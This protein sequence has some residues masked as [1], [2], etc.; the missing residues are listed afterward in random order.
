[1]YGF[2]LAW[3]NAT[4]D[5]RRFLTSVAGITLAV[6]LM[7]TQVGFLTGLYDSQVELV[8]QLHADIIITNALKH[9]MTHNEPF[10]R[11]R[12]QQAQALPEVQTAYPLYIE[13]ALSWWRNPSTGKQRPIR[14]LAF[15]PADPIFLN[16]DIRVHAAALNL[17]NTVLIDTQSK[18]YFGERAAGVVSELSGKRA[19][20][21]GTFRL[22]TDFANE[23]NIMMSARNFLKYFSSPASREARLGKVELGI[24]HLAPGTVAASAVAALR[25]VLPR[26]VT[27]YTKQAYLEHERQ[28]WRKHTPIGAVFGLGAAMGFVIGVII[29][30]Q[31]LYT[32]VVDHLPQFA[33]MKAIG[34]HNQAVIGMVIM[35]ALLLALTGFMLGFICSYAFYELL[36]RWTGLLMRLTLLRMVFVLWSSSWY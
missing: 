29:C 1:M 32:D 25:R 8:N 18:P 15:N 27:I 23:G 4:H 13:Y 28:Y 11:R 10:A 21:V 14:V 16:P 2:R 9:T 17:P 20:V 22:G 33:T 6:F 7:F 12:L 5:I 36:I 24:V 34:Y 30:Y 3:N 31:I 35:Q 26:D 19:R